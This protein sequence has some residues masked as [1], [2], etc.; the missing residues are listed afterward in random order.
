MSWDEFWSGVEISGT[1]GW[2]PSPPP[3]DKFAELME[4]ANLRQDICRTLS[5][6]THYARMTGRRRDTCWGCAARGMG[7]VSV[8]HANDRQSSGAPRGEGGIFLTSHVTGTSI[9]FF[10]QCSSLVSWMRS[11]SPTRSRRL[12]FANGV[13]AIIYSDVSPDVISRRTYFYNRPV[14]LSGI[15]IIMDRSVVTFPRWR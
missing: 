3:S 15:I 4:E 7:C 2:H 5:K 10:P 14:R 11:P 6:V 13:T 8:I 12:F 1:L 9:N